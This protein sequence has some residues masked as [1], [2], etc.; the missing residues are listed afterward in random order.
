[1]IR[2][3]FLFLLVAASIGLFWY[4][5][6]R[7]VAMPP[8]PLAQGQKLNCLSYA[9]F[10]G[11]Q[12]PFDQPLRI[13]DAQIESD[14]QKLAEVTSCIRTYSA[15]RAQGKITRIAGKHGL[16]VLQGIWIG[17]NLADNRREIEGALRLA[18]RHPGV[19]EAF[20]VGNETLLRGELGAA[21]IKTYLEEV[22]RRSGL[23]VTYADVWEFWLKAPELAPAADFI[24]IHILPYWEDEPVAATEA[25]A[26]VREVREK[27]AKIFA[28]KEILIGEVG[29]PS[30]G[31]MRDGALP[32]PANQALVLSGVVEAAKA[33][34][35]RVNLIEAFDQPWK[36]LLEGTVGGYWGMFDDGARQLKFRWGEPVSNHSRWRLEAALGIGAA[37]LVFAAAFLARRKHDTSEESWRRDLA[38]AA[39]ALGAGL[40][41]GW[42]VLGLPMEPPEPGDRLRSA[43]M[44]VLV[45]A[46]ADGRRRRGGAQRAARQSR[47]R[48][49]C[50]A[51]ARTQRLER[52]ARDPVRCDSG[53]RHPCG[54]RARLRPA[55]QG[56]STR[57]A[58]GTGGGARHRRAWSRSQ[59]HR[60]PASPSGSPPACL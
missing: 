12:A 1:M 57:P 18:R 58:V 2:S 27:V 45:A 25:A 30:E 39:I 4:A 15:A 11:S 42:A 60:S 10:H 43:G 40:V 34:N 9:P 22:K 47:R 49:Q 56:L 24:T 20:I 38:V 44:I 37:F 5:M 16:K 32:S 48:P 23:P 51:P 52:A 28:G 33:G 54:A 41:F 53:R 13:P 3:V 31:R 26:H 8:S 55:L 21:R 29:W 19:I 59:P 7:P 14:L 46:R 17:R 50:A 36:R 6:G 35:W